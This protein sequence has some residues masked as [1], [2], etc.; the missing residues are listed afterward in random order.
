M[1]RDEAHEGGDEQDGGRHRE[2]D[3]SGAGRYRDARRQIDLSRSQV[4]ALDGRARLR[5]QRGEHERIAHHRDRR[6]VQLEAQ[7]QA[8]WLRAGPD[9]QAVRREVQVVDPPDA[10]GGG[11]LI[12]PDTRQALHGQALQ[13][14]RPLRGPLGRRA[15]LEEIQQIGEVE[16]GGAAAQNLDLRR[17]HRDLG[18]AHV[19]DEERQ[20]VEPNVDTLDLVCSFVRAGRLHLHALQRQVA[21]EEIQVD[22]VQQ[23]DAVC[24]LGDLSDRD[25]AHD[26]G[27]NRQE[28]PTEHH[29]RHE[30]ADQ[31]LA[32]AAGDAEHQTSTPLR[33]SAGGAPAPRRPAARTP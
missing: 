4:E 19:A 30:D 32:R 29:H 2:A 11:R 20:I 24:E 10:L 23:Q 21:R 18:H 8:A 6:V 26:L 14:H 17:H 31:D 15:S 1:K 28:Q 13:G 3:P 7:L 22:V 25:A 5:R 27:Q 16:L 9:H 12:S 33:A